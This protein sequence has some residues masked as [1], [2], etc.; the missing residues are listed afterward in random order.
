MKADNGITLKLR[1]VWASGVHS[2]T[3]SIQT[4]FKV[5]EQMITQGKGSKWEEDS[6]I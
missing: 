6:E 5:T 1:E 4:V 3:D 2:E